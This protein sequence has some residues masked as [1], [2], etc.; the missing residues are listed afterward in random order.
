MSLFEDSQ[1]R[2]RETYFVQ[3]PLKNRPSLEKTKQAISMV[4][5]RFKL[6][7]VQADGD[8]HFESLTL[9]ASDDYA[10]VDVCFTSGEEVREDAIAF[11]E[12]AIAI[13][14]SP[15][16]HKRLDELKKYDARFDVLHFEQI[17]DG[18]DEDDDLN[19][20]LDPSALLLV[21]DALAEL[22]GGIAVDPQSGTLFG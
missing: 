18:A 1:Y 3:F 9:V 15:E 12:D 22:T 8:G 6:T 7:H 13:G 14:V 10:A 11:A 4:S 5:D 16:D 17:T 19:G 2:W 20:M 21:L